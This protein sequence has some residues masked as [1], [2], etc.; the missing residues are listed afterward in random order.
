MTGPEQPTTGGPEQRSAAGPERPAPATGPA[1]PATGPGEQPATGP[2]EQ[3]ATGAEE[4]RRSGLRDPE[5][6]VRSLGAGALGIE[7]L[8]LLLAIQPIRAVGADLG[9][10]AIGAVV[11]LAVAAV[12][13]AG[14]MRRPWAWHAGTV[15]QGLLILG[16]LLHWSLLALGVIFALAWAYALHVRRVIL[17]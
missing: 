11:A 6:A 14:M 10:P 17:G 13:L 1:Q 8:V 4:P 2:G 12:V 15:L 16:G 3:P 9:G 5:R 7:A